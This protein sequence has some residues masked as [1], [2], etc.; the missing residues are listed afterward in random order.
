M[1]KRFHTHVDGTGIGL[2]IVK[3]IIENKDGKIEVKSERDK[4]TI[5]TI[6]FV[7]VEKNLK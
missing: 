2:Y 4:G 7:D 1:F 5:F 3:R 6:Y